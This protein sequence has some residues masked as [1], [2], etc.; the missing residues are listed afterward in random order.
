LISDEDLE[1]CI[2]QKEMDECFFYS[3]GEGSYSNRRM[4]KTLKNVDPK[5]DFVARNEELEIQNQLLVEENAELFR[6]IS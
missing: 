4:S 6:E 5:F 3:N 1:F 2:D